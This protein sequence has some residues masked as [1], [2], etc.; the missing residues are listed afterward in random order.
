[1]VYTDHAKGHP[2]VGKNQAGNMSQCCSCVKPYNLIIKS[3]ICSTVKGI[4]LWT[5]RNYCFEVQSLRFASRCLALSLIRAIFRSLTTG[6]ETRVV[7]AFAAA[8]PP[9][10]REIYGCICVCMYVCMYVCI[11]IC[12]CIYRFWMYIYIYIYICG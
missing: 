4:P 12:G 11:Y 9:T 7:R 1:M 2:I 5:P 8:N 10:N 3:V 6:A